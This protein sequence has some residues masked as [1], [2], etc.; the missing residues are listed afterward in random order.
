MWTCRSI[1][2]EGGLRACAPSGAEGTGTQVSE[3]RLPPSFHWPQWACLPS[4]IHRLGPPRC[5]QGFLPSLQAPEKPF[6]GAF[7]EAALTQGFEDW[8]RPPCASPC[9]L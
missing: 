1:P 4:P 6:Q 5:L 2:Q 9:L 3:A 8:L 7:G